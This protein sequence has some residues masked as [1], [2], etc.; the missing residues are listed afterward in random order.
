MHTMA[1]FVN[2]SN[3][4]GAVGTRQ[5]QETSR[6]S[7]CMMAHLKTHC[8]CW[9]RFCRCTHCISGAA[10]AVPAKGRPATTWGHNSPLT[11]EPLPRWECTSSILHIHLTQQH[12]VVTHASAGSSTA[13][14]AI[15]LDNHS[16]QQIARLALPTNICHAWTDFGLSKAIVST[17]CGSTFTFSLHP[18]VQPCCHCLLHALQNPTCTVPSCCYL[19]LLQQLGCTDCQSSLQMRLVRYALVL[20][21]FSRCC[22]V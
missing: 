3:S 13:A 2:T 19:Y 14:S 22:M 18:Q 8:I 5:W 4:V 1:A 12:L 20:H 16:L 7:W 6:A 15:W 17:R 9:H 10:G 11:A 21:L